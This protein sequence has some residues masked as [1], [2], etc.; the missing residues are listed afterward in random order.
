VTDRPIAPEHLRETPKGPEMM[1]GQ[2]M[3]SASASAQLATSWGRR[4][5]YVLKRKIR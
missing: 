1:N 4:L 5:G 2:N 3:S